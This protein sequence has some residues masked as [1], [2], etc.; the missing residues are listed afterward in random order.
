MLF[1]LR[2]MDKNKVH[3]RH[4]ILYEFQQQK[5]TLQAWRS[6]SAVLGE[7]SVSHSTIKYW[8]RRFNQGDFSLEDKE[9]SGAPKKSEF[10]D[11]QALLDEN[12]CQTQEELA[13]QLGITQQAVSIQL[14]AMGKIQKLGKWLPHELSEANKKARID[15][16]HSLLVKQQRKSFLWKIVTGDE[17]WIFYENPKRKHSW[18]DK[19]KPSTSTPKRNIHS[20]KV[21]LCIWWDI[22][23]VLYYELLK[24]NETINS[25][26][27]RNQLLRLNE[28]IENKRPFSGHGRRPIKLLHDN[29]R[30]HVSKVVRDTLTSLGWDVLMHPAYSPDI[31]PSDFH[32]FRGMQNALQGVHLSSIEEMRKWVDEFIA[33]KPQQFFF[34]GIH[35]L[36]EKWKKVLDNNGEYFDD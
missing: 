12:S 7:D 31:A 23:G 5:S 3:V 20:K 32:L 14:H 30:P 33:S 34:D 19:G 36:P 16:C 11:L 8:F 9:R 10:D 15:I 21:M 27:Y 13:D 29:A 2:I 25:E 18:V 28:E 35:Q 22:K 17:K 24:P 1:S 26:R 6:I 4:C